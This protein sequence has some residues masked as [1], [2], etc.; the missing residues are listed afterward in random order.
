MSVAA[1]LGRSGSD[2]RW[3]VRMAR[4]PK[5]LR[6]GEAEASVPV[7]WYPSGRVI[8]ANLGVVAVDG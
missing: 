5:M 1:T 3:A 4:S 6:L 2:D 8:V 7:C